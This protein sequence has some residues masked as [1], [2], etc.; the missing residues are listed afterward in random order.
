MLLPKDHL[1]FLKF[2]FRG[3]C[4]NTKH[5]IVTALATWNIGILDSELSSTDQKA[6]AFASSKVLYV[7]AFS[8]MI[9]MCSAWSDWVGQ[10]FLHSPCNS[11]LLCPL[12]NI[13]KS[14]TTYSSRTAHTSRLPTSSYTATELSVCHCHSFN[15]LYITLKLSADCAVKNYTLVELWNLTH[16]SSRSSC[17]HSWAK[18]KHWQ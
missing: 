17:V 15:L 2:Y 3:E 6:A 13:H 7:W 5:C 4:F 9:S 14:V 8:Q 18:P 1:D 16:K 11:W 10:L 12:H